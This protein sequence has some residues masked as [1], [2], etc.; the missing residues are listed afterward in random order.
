[1]NE[2][3]SGQKVS[4]L[5]ALN[6]GQLGENIILRRGVTI[7][8]GEGVSIEGVT[9]PVVN[10]TG[11]TEPI[12][13]GKYGALV[14]YTK[15]ENAGNIEEGQTPASIIRQLCQHVIGMNPTSVGNME[16][17]PPLR[18][19]EE[20]EAAA[21]AKEEQMVQAATAEGL[22]I[23]A[24]KKKLVIDPDTLIHQ[25]FLSDQERTVGEV[26]QET[27]IEIKDF[28]RYELGQEINNEE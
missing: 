18:T 9:H 27:G 28:L 24:T 13:V 19:A 3:I 14:T 23:Q 17:L 12:Q 16:D 15:N 25:D 22:E 5:V 7:A 2:L 8:V 6:I 1:M 10:D 20:R 21:N 4:D 11:I 26:L